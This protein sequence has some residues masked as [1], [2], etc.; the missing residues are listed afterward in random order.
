M[1]RD[2]AHW[3]AVA[4]LFSSAPLT[5]AWA[6]ALN[7]LADAC[8]GRHGQLIGVSSDAAVAFN[9]MPRADAGAITEFVA[10]NGG[11]PRVNPRI[12]VGRRA[13]VMHAWHEA[14]C[15]SEDELRRNFAHADWCRRNDLSHGSQATLVRDQGMLIKL[16][17][18][19]S[20][21]GGPPESQDRRA[22]EALIGP[23]RAAVQTEILL[24]GR[25]ADLLAGA[26]DGLALAAFIC[27][28]LG[29]VRAVTA[30][31]EAVLRRGILQVRRARLGAEGAGAA[32]LEAAID[33]ARSDRRTPGETPS[34]SV[35]LR[36]DGQVEVLDI[37]ALPSAPHAFGFEP[38]L[39]VVARGGGRDRGVSRDLIQT[40]FDLTPAE[41]AIALQ[42]AEG[43]STEDVA[44]AQ[45]I[46]VSTLRSHV[47]A[48][49]W[50]IGV[51]RRAELAARLQAFR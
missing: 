38:R 41:S 29:A 21:G 43:A 17:V 10:I 12:K 35:V 20:E 36:R 25:G 7:A 47:K 23:V 6:P 26:L 33:K 4:D 14:R 39:L 28:G 42:L 27:D 19:R 51:N 48:L 18:G 37:V 8:G 11:D 1:V 40:A 30:E 13:R 44:A 34:G 24:E 2:E 49:F 50:K 22:F 31:A 16:A 3:S 46:S 32:A 15:S 5:G 45:R 9:W